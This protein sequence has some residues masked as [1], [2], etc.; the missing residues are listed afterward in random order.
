M[1]ESTSL[2]VN[3]APEIVAYRSVKQSVGIRVPHLHSRY[4]IYYNITGATGF[5]VDKK[6][7]SCSGRDLFIIPKAKVHKAIVTPGSEYERC[8]VSIDSKIVDYINS[9]P[10]ASRNL[11]WL[12]CVGDTLT[13]KVT[14][15]DAMHEKILSFVEK[16]NANQG[17]LSKFAL[18]LDFLEAVGSVFKSSP[19]ATTMTHESLSVRALIAIEESFQNTKIADI[20]E[21]LYV[22]GG[23]LG[24]VFKSEMGM[25]ISDYLILRKIAEAK[26]LLYMGL[27]VKEACHLSGFGNYSNFIRTFKNIEGYPPGKFE[28]ISESI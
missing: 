15:D 7:Y 16:Y 18:L 1:D 25:S 14:P 26:K 8:I 5:I 20:A 22:T 27:S 6:V 12:D 11:A 2:Y 28:I 4:E 3:S 9:M 17:E 23:H 19:I 24:K 10:H 13:A 21:R